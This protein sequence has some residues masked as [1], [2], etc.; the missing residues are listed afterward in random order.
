MSIPQKNAIDNMVSNPQSLQAERGGNAFFLDS[1]TPSIPN[2]ANFLTLMTMRQFY[3]GDAAQTAIFDKIAKEENRYLL[4]AMDIITKEHADNGTSEAKAQ[5]KL[6][7]KLGRDFSAALKVAS[8]LKNKA[9]DV[10]MDELLKPLT[11]D[12]IRDRRT[13][14]LR[15]KVDVGIK[16]D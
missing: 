12:L 13:R 11:I 5:D 6:H 3:K 4:K 8:M 14:A 7:N 1:Y 9:D 10:E 15:G 16:F 2:E